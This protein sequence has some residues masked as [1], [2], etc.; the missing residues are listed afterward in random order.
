MHSAADVHGGVLTYTFC[1]NLP[2]KDRPKGNPVLTLPTTYNKHIMSEV[3]YIKVGTGPFADLLFQ[4][5]GSAAAYD[6]QAGVKDGEENSAVYTADV[7]DA[8]RSLLPEFHS[9]STALIEAV[10]GVT[11]GVNA[12]ATAKAKAKAKDGSKVA[13]VKE[14]WITFA[15][16]AESTL[17]A[18]GDD[19]LAKWK[20]LE[21]QV[22]ELAQGM[23]SDSSPSSRERGPGKEYLAKAD[24]VLTRSPERIEAAISQMLAS[25]ND[26]EVERDDAGKPTRESLASLVREYM[27]AGI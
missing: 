24:E 19:G 4:G 14:S 8:Y 12:D 25:V 21:S 22:R 2:Q 17:K 1:G 13:D 27:K 16:R 6:A 26:Y 18:Q 23:K 20:E 15:N 7:S 9:K 3:T 10:S 11:R 5:H